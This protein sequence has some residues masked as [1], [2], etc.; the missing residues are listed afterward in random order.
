MLI[1]VADLYACLFGIQDIKKKSA[2]RRL[3]DGDNT[4]KLTEYE[5][6]RKENVTKNDEYLSSLGFENRQVINPLKQYIICLIM[7]NVLQART[8]CI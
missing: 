8:L 1:Q 2:K 3:D 7:F 5:S 6:F 4:G